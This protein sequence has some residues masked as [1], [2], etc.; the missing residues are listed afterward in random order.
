MENGE[1]KPLV[2]VIMPV[3]NGKDYI[4]NSVNSVFRQSYSSIELIIVNDGSGDGSGEIL[5]EMKVEAGK[6]LSVRLI[7]QENQGICAARNRALGVAAG[8]YIM[9]MDQDDVIREDCV[10][11]L[12]REMEEKKAELVIGGFDLVDRQGR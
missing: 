4:R 2:S 3:Y 8:K 9:F 11:V 7:H 6:N 12:C 10:E 5:E 1:R